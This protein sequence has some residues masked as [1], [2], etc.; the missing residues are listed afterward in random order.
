MRHIGFQPLWGDAV[1]R[2]G[3]D[4]LLLRWLVFPLWL[5]EAMWYKPR[6]VGAEDMHA[7]ARVCSLPALACADARGGRAGKTFTLC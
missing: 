3:Q 6:C 2:L 4:S 1:E 5:W 7:G